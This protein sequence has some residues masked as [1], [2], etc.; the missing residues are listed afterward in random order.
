[1]SEGR[2]AEPSAAGVLG[3][4][5]ASLHVGSPRVAIVHDYITQ[6]GGAERVV[7]ALL[8]A[9][10]DA[11]LITSVFNPESTFEQFAEYDVETTWL[12]RVAF[13]RRDPRR[14]LPLLALAMRT[15]QLSDVD[16]VLCS[17]SG[18]AHGVRS[19]APKVVY[20]YNPARWLYQFSQY[21]VNHH[22]IV[23]ALAWLVGPVLRRWDRRVAA[24]AFSYLTLSRV[25]ADRIR[26]QYGLSAHIVPPPVTLDA[27]GPQT[28]V[29]GL[30]P[31]FLLTVS[32]SRNYK[33]VHAIASAV[34]VLPDE[35]LVVVGELPEGRWSNRTVA[36]SDLSDAELRWLYANCD[37]VVAASYEDFGLT[38]VEGYTFG[39][40]ALCLRAGGFL[41]TMVE[42]TT[43]VFFD[44]PATKP[45]VDAVR[46]FRARPWSH[47]AIRAHGD[48][49]GLAR[50]S[51]RLMDE[52]RRAADAT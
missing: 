3:P 2:E 38:P 12:N 35:R 7:L 19:E 47:A 18:W 34:E 36:V 32:R 43:G 15:V 5:F 29:E 17:S 11:R 45:I 39:K 37:G 44:Q 40:P 52:V 10:P 49:Y 9:F 27:A 26:N 13:F 22:W 16:V 51:E 1:M 21:S 33:N 20:C 42:G 14:A 46:E 31:G 23:R 30:S 25:V 28:V 48:Q 8:E 6:K 24:T 50:F 4:L 41:D